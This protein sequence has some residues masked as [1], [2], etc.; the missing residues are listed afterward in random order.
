MQPEDDP[1]LKLHAE[2]EDEIRSILTG[3]FDNSLCRTNVLLRIVY[4]EFMAMDDVEDVSE[5]AEDLMDI[6]LSRANAD[7]TLFNTAGSA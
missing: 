1:H 5:L 4:E 3:T 7:Y 6:I 2:I